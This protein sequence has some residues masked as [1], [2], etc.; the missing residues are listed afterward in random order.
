[1]QHNELSIEI[2]KLPFEVFNYTLNPDNTPLW[3]D[4]IVCEE[5]DTPT[6]Q[7]GTRYRNKSQSGQWNEYEVVDFI[8]PKTFT[9]KQLNSMYM[10]RYSFEALSGD[11]TKLTYA[12]WMESGELESPF[13]MLPLRK[14]KGL[15]ESQV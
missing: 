11:R 15:L 2:R 12:E 3:V 5:K 14:L 13:D 7:L 10:V 4:G 1:M 6:P 8:P 9:F